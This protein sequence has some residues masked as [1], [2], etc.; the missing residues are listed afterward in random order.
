MTRTTPDYDRQNLDSAIVILGNIPKYGG[1][2]AAIV[3]WA[4]R[5]TGRLAA[6]PGATKAPVDLALAQH[7]FQ[8]TLFES[9]G[10]K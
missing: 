7:P 9:E 6:L 3:R 1:E 4:R 2:E 5:I 8:G 10:N